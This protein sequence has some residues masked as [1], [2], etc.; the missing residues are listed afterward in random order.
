MSSLVSKLIPTNVVQYTENQKHIIEKTKND[1][2]RQLYIQIIN[3]NQQNL[4]SDLFTLLNKLD[5]DLTQYDKIVMKFIIKHIT[6]LKEQDNLYQIMMLIFCSILKLLKNDGIKCK[7]DP[8][9][10]WDH[11]VFIPLLLM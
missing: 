2:V 5:G 9:R 3:N 7:A 4:N 1:F 11:G 8:N 10:G 6:L